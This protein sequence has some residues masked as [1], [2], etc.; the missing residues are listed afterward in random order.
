M[1]W[2]TLFFDSLDHYCHSGLST[3]GDH[4]P[5]ADWVGF[6]VVRAVEEH[7][8]LKGLKSKITN[9]ERHFPQL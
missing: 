4:I 3:A 1:P 9:E 8:P 6:R 7:E 2:K 5:R